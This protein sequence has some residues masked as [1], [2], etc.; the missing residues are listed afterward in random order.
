MF[1]NHHS[2]EDSE[3]VPQIRIHLLGGFEAQVGDD[4]LSLQPA[5]Q[6]LIALVALSP[7]GINRCRTA[8]QLWPDTNEDR[9]KANLRSTLWRLNKMCDSIITATKT[10]LRLAPEVWVDAR[11]GIETLA[12]RARSDGDEVGLELPRPFQAL[13]SE[14]LPDWYDDWLII[15]RERLRQLTLNTLEQRSRTALKRGETAQAVEAGLAAVAIDPLRESSRRLVVE[16]HIAQGN[17]SA[18]RQEIDR[19]RRMLAGHSGINPTTELQSLI[20]GAA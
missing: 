9:A 8:F 19:Y 12:A 18:A 7:R 2:V 6:R 5:M 15:E 16:A 20:S 3:T 1:T 14:L 10:H 13:Q 4:V 17:V 11:D